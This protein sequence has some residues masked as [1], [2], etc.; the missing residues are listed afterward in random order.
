MTDKPEADIVSKK[1]VA[2]AFA[3]YAKET[4]L[5]AFEVY[6]V[7]GQG[8]SAQWTRIGAAWPHKDGEG[9]N[10]TLRALPHGGARVVLRFPKAKLATPEGAA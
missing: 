1:L 5:P 6:S 7:E 8:K 2:E 9:L 3:A 10:V 4:N